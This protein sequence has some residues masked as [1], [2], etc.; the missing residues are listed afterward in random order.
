MK[1]LRDIEQRLRNGKLPDSDMSYR[2][3][4]VWRKILLNQRARRK[5]R[6]PILLSP[7]VWALG[8]ILVVL[9]FLFYVF[10]LK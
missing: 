8:S 4:F 5:M 1:D 2:H 7:W 10:Y 9:L 3:K 6:T